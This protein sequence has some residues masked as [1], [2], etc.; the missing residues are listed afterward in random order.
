MYDYELFVTFWEEFLYPMGLSF[1]AV[2]AVVL[3]ITADLVS[4]IVV[5]ICV[6]MTDLF[7]GGLIFYWDLSA[8][9]VVMV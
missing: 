1:S 6:L 8:N 2:M 9:P 5:A 4:T 7:L 3:L